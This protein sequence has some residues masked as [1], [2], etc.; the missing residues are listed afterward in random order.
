MNRKREAAGWG[1]E[2]EEEAWVWFVWCDAVVPLG[3]VGV[4]RPSFFC[5]FFWFGGGGLRSGRIIITMWRCGQE[6]VFFL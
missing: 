5:C 3:S 6:F 4:G 2:E 1:K